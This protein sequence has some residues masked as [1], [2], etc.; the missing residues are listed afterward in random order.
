MD[1]LVDDGAGIDDSGRCLWI[2]WIIDVFIELTL[3]KRQLPTYYGLDDDT[4]DAPA[5]AAAPA[6]ESS[7]PQL[8][9]AQKQFFGL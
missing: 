3:T 9:D 1:N 2:Y 5:P 8:T 7:A 6:A 4:P